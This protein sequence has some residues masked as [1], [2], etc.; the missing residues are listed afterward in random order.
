M[1]AQHHAKPAPVG[2]PLFNA[3]TLTAGILIAIMAV[4]LLVR[5][6]YGL[7]SVTAVPPGRRDLR[8]GR[9][10]RAGR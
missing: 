8:G 6:F 9:G 3:V 1:S 2:G 4:I 5:F 7:G 10:W